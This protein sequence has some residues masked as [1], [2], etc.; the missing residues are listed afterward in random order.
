MKWKREK[1]A[2]LVLKIWCFIVSWC[3][4]KL[5]NIRLKY[6]GL[7][8]SHYLS[9]PASSKDAMFNMTKIEL[10]FISDGDVYLLFEKDMRGGVS[11]ISKRYS[12]ANTKY[13]KAYNPK[14]VNQGIL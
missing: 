4:W 3:V 2:S 14:Q 10:E 13:L 6:Y 8:P 1:I 9:A 12:K 5:W 7:C 11:D